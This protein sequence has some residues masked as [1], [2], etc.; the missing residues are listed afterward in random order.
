MSEPTT[1]MNVAQPWRAHY[2]RAASYCWQSDEAPADS[3]DHRKHI[4]PWLS[5]LF[6]AEH[7]SLLTGNGFTTGVAAMAGAPTIG[8]QPATLSAI[9]VRLLGR[10]PRRAPSRQAAVNRTSKIRYAQFGN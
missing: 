4:E 7:L 10:L 2:V 1:T 9:S 5:A 8:M 3:A 6:Q